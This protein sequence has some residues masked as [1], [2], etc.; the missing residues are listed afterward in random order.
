MAQPSDGKP[1]A[2]RTPGATVGRS[3]SSTWIVL[4][5]VLGMVTASGY[6]LYSREPAFAPPAAAV[7]GLPGAVGVSRAAADVPARTLDGRSLRL[8]E[9][10]GK[11][12]VLDFWATW[13]PPCREEIPHLVRLFGRYQARGLEV[14]GLTIESPADSEKIRRFMQRFRVNYLV[15][16]APQELVEVYIGPGEQPIPQTLVF[17][18][19]GRLQAHLIGF[20]PKRDPQRLESLITKLL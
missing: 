3:R 1:M 17:D 4:L 2:R 5:V 12:V 13:C 18:R 14:V 6:Y 20:D 9:L 8:G 10:R 15:G 7:D 16:F 19:Q 11:V